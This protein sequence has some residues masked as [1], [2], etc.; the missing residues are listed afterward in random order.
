M[1]AQKRKLVILGAGGNAGVLFHKFRESDTTEVVG[2]A[3]EHDF[4]TITERFGLPIV[5]VEEMEKHFPACDHVAMA[6]VNFSGLN[7]NRERLFKTAKA[8]GYQL[9]NYI[10]PRACLDHGVSLGENVAILDF[11]TIQ[12]DARI[13]DNVVIWPGAL[14]LDEGVVGSHV[15]IGANA[16]IAGRSRLGDYSILGIGAAIREETVVGKD[17]TIGA[18]AVVTRSLHDNTF[19]RPQKMFIAEDTSRQIWEKK[20]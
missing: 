14:V 2:F 4:L 13:G 6:A 1:A 19:I 15:T 12:F 11:C 8:K 5:E 7:R 10:S 16:I 3:V 18:G 17:C 9:I 20:K